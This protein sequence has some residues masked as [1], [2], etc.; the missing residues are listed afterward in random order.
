MNLLY[1]VLLF[2]L[3]CLG[4][5]KIVVC[6]FAAGFSKQILCE[7]LKQ[8]Q[9]IKNENYSQKKVDVNVGLEPGRWDVRM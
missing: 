3:M 7:K 8:H 5:G 4:M 1:V 2:L 9:Q 6:H